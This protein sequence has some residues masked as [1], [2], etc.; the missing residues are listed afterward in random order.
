MTVGGIFFRRPTKG[1]QR[2]LPFRRQSLSSCP[3]RL[4][5]T[6][7]GVLLIDRSSILSEPWVSIARFQFLLYKVYSRCQGK[8]Q[9]NFSNFPQNLLSSVILSTVCLKAGLRSRQ[10]HQSW[11]SSTGDDS[12]CFMLQKTPHNNALFRV[13][14]TDPSTDEYCSV[15]AGKYGY[16]AQPFRDS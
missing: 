4:L 5:K 2:A 3:L 6:P 8:K 7:A 10:P 11:L 12:V 14:I 9:K 1:L 13:P 15:P 16:H